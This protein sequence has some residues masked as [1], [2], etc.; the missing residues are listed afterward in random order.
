YIPPRKGRRYVLRVIREILF[1][2]PKRRGTNL[3]GALDFL[4][5]V[6]PHKAIAVVI[7]DFIENQPRPPL[8]PNAEGAGRSHFSTSL[9]QANRRHDVVAVQITD[10]FE[11]ELPALGRLVLR[12][13]E[14]GEVI[15]VNTGDA[16]RRSG[17]GRRRQE[18]QAELMRLFRKLGID[19]IQLRTDQP[20][21]AA[22]G[23]FFETREKRRWHG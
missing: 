4:N 22:L 8:G 16:R 21:A 9:R 3:V 6:T 19:A 14:T 7:S 20:Y 15:E 2:E 10:R 13:A 5:R 12:D 17:F 18:A 23:R 11:Q 1:F